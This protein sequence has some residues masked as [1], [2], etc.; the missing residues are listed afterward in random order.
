MK[1]M[2]MRGMLHYLIDGDSVI[3]KLDGGE[4]VDVRVGVVDVPSHGPRAEAAKE[5][6]RSWIGRRVTVEPIANYTVHS[7]TPA[8]GTD[9]DGNNL[10]IQLLNH[11][12]RLSRFQ[13]RSTPLLALALLN[14]E[15][16]ILEKR[17]NPQSD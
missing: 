12:I 17:C 13:I 14:S 10:G 6:I 15:T 16:S 9:D 11:G 3:V 1:G 2:L 7:E 8:I 5:L 4:K